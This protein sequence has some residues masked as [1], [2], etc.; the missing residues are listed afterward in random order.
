MVCECNTGAMPTFMSYTSDL[1]G[2]WS[3]PV[4]VAGGG[5][6]PDLNVAPYIFG[7]GTLLAMYRSNSGSNVHILTASDWR[8]PS[9]YERSDANLAA[10]LPED[11]FLWRDANGVFHSIHHAYPYPIGPHAWSEDGL[12]WHKAAGEGNWTD[13]TGLWEGPARAYPR[14]THFSDA[15]SLMPGCRER[16]SLVFGADGTTPIAL[17]SPFRRC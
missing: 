10:S 4:Q 15:E 5:Y 3:I 12:N 13:G 7:N 6:L 11:P 1:D 16:P 14:E 17:W 8:D 9:T 2:E